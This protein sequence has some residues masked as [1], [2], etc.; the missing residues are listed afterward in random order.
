ML[1]QHRRIPVFQRFQIDILHIE[2]YYARKHKRLHLSLF[3]S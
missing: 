2:R 3:L 1:F